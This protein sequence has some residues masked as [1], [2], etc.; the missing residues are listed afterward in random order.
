MKLNSLNI[1]DKIEIPFCLQLDFSGEQIK[2]VDCELGYKLQSGVINKILTII[3][4]EDTN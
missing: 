1:C 3:C 4:V 2:C